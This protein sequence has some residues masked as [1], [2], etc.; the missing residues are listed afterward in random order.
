MRKSLTGTLMAAATAFGLS[1]C[2]NHLP[3]ADPQLDRLAKHAS[4]HQD[5]PTLLA[6][7]IRYEYGQGV[8]VDWKIAARFYAAAADSPPGGLFMGTTNGIPMNISRASK[9]LPEAKARLQALRAK[10]KA[11]GY[12]CSGAGWSMIFC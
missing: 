10:M 12:R 9:G 3:G 11:A 6:L 2:A 5:K 1:A 7:G 4:R 8:P